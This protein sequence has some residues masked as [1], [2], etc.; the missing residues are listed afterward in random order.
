MFFNLVNE[1]WSSLESYMT[2]NTTQH[3]TT[4]IQHGITRDSTSA[5]RDNTSTTRVQHETKQVQNNL[6]FILIYSYDCCML[7]AWY[8]RLYST[9]Y[10]VELRTLKITFS[11][12]SQNRTREYEGSGLLQLCFCL[13]VY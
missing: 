10:V 6:N 4:R 13:P 11:S 3:K 12:N 2:N 7:G 1:K 9:V 8:I 5:T